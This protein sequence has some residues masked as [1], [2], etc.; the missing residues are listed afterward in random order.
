MPEV[1][2]RELENYLK[3]KYENLILKPELTDPQIQ[4]V[5]LV[6]LSNS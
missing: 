3:T 5:F 2:S 1:I 6:T 4:H